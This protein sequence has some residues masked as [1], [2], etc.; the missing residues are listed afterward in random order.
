MKIFIVR[1]GQ[2]N[3]NAA[4]R[5]QGH[6]DIPLN[7]MGL[8]HAGHAAE[9]LK[10]KSIA[11]IYSS[12]LLRARQTAEIISK[13][14]G[15]K[16]IFTPALRELDFGLLTGKTEK[17]IEK[18]HPEFHAKKKQSPFD[19]MRPGGESYELLEQRVR[20]LLEAIVRK[21]AN[22]SVCLVCHHGSSRIVLRALLEIE[23]NEATKILHP[24]D[25]VYEFDVEEKKIIHHR[26]GGLS[27]TGLL[28]KQETF[29][30]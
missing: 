21:H 3:W 5:L 10:N 8:L 20:P 2:T 30:Q 7:E 4:G 11:I 13:V 14:T 16:A 22:E 19:A 29:D 1:H 17:E 24:Q 26:A 25:C 12:D 28:K 15:A 27:A 23:K 9:F 18:E 6:A